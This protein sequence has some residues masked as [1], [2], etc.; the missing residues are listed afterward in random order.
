M[1][2]IKAKP[3]E[4]ETPGE[5]LKVGAADEILNLIPK[6][7]APVFPREITIGGK[8]VLFHFRR[9]SYSKCAA[10]DAKQYRR[11]GKGNLIHDIAYAETVGIAHQLHETIVHN[12]NEGKTGEDGEELEP[13]WVRLFTLEQLLGKNEGEGLMDNDSPE[14]KEL[15]YKLIN[16][17]WEVVPEWNPVAKSL[18]IEAARS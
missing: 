1:L 13:D 17:V 2:D 18:A 12:V 15:V 4:Q 11:D 16:A 10:I 9:H 5:A 7:G 3:S 14:A 8:V 6:N